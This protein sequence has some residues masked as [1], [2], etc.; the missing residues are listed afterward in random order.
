[1][2]RNEYIISLLTIIAKTDTSEI[3]CSYLVD[4]A[5]HNTINL[6]EDELIMLLEN[7][8]D[9][10]ECFQWEL[11]KLMLDGH[12]TESNLYVA[13]IVYKYLGKCDFE[14]AFNY[15]GYDPQ[16]VCEGYGIL[17]LDELSNKEIAKDIR[18]ILEE[19]A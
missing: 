15:L 16:M 10:R 1:M 13:R 12:L 14:M 17:S 5:E 19:L 6:N 2:R 4:S 7:A 18:E 9:T 8:S 11:L 3:P